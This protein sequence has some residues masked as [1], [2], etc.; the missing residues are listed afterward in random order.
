MEK[1]KLPA[2]RWVILVLISL[3]AFM[4]NYAQFQISIYA[5]TIMADLGIDMA[6]FS[7][8]LLV[9]MLAGA[10]FSIPFGTLGDRFGAKKVV[11]VLAIVSAIG[12]FMR[13][14]TDT[15]ELQMV[16]MFMISLSLAAINANLLKLFGA[17]FQEKTGFAMGIFFAT[18]CMGIVAAQALGFLFPSVFVAYMTTAV[19]M[20]V[21]TILWVVFV[22]D[23]PK[24]VEPLP[25]EPVVQYLGVAMRS[26]GVWL[27][28][29]AVG[30]GMASTTAYAGIAPQML[31]LGKGAEPALAGVM[32][33]ALTLGSAIGSIAG[34]AMCG[35]LNRTKPFIIIATVLG[36]AI[37][38]INWYTPL[39]MGMWVVLILNGIITALVGPI[40]QAMPYVLPEIRGKYA[41]S[42]GGIV[43]TVSLLMCYFVP[44]LIGF[45]AGDDFGLNL[46]LEALCYLASVACI[47]ALPELGPKG[48]VAQETAR[49]DAEDAAAAAAAAQMEES[50]SAGASA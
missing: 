24:G 49:L 33:A 21:L 38:L 37:M 10:I 8:L 11:T 14:Y 45:V 29:L 32:A 4:G 2:Y 50:A 26:K 35:R 39:G 30:F 22:R 9:P 42:A 7:M 41:G 46:G 5:V 3:F 31:E 25:P 17:W 16:S 36:A 18:A 13:A 40:L 34:P 15:F 23:L 47:L 20:A 44:V 43:G 1:R 6:G 19:V 28:A 48:A 12:A 27:I